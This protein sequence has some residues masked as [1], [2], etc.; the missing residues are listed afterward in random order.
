V[1]S[2]VTQNTLILVRKTCAH[3]TLRLFSSGDL[4]GVPIAVASGFI[5]GTATVV[6]AAASSSH[7]VV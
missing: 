2:A 1:S 5:A 6:L 7:L 4:A 3:Q